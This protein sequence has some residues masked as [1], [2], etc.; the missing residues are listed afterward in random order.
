MVANQPIFENYKEAY[1]KRYGREEQQGKPRTVFL[2]SVFQGNEEALKAAIHEG[3]V[4]CWVQDGQPYCGFKATTAGVEKASSSYQK[5][6]GGGIELKTRSTIPW[7][8]LLLAWLG[9]LAVELQGLEGTVDKHLNSEHQRRDKKQLRMLAWPQRWSTWSQ[10]PRMRTRGW[11]QV[12]WNSF[13]NALMRLRRRS[14]KQ[15][16]WKSKTGFHR[17]K[18]YWLGRSCQM[19]WLWPPPTSK[20]SWASRLMQ[21]VAWV[22]SLNSLRLCWKQGRNFRFV[23]TKE[24]KPCKLK[25][26]YWQKPIQC[27]CFPLSRKGC[28]TISTIELLFLK[29]DLRHWWKKVS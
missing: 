27:I 6:S 12:V 1:H 25:L 21:H 24:V 9:N 17:M 11:K 2:W 19:M 5:L 14:S 28:K 20:F 10:M 23:S 18:A 22:N 29:L 16:C 7:A 26:A 15:Q 8:R 13:Q 3:S 4:S